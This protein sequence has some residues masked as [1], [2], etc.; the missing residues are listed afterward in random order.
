MALRIGIVDTGV[1]PWHSHVRGAVG[2]CRIFVDA[3]GFIAEDDDFRDP[4]GHGTAIAG[5]VREAFADAEIFAVRVFD[6]EDRT[7]PS[8]VARGLLRAAAEG[9]SH[10][11]LSLAV[12]AGAGTRV[13]AEA[14]AAALDAGCVLVA[15]QHPH[16]PDALPAALLGV[17]V[18]RADD[19]L[20]AGRVRREGPLRLAAP[21][22]PRE[23]AAA[24]QRNNLRGPSF[25]CARVL[26]HLAREGVGAEG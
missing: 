8:L 13:L 19:S 9:C 23:L 12:P 14:C 26:L 10:I 2:G 24:L 3:Q 11:N 25:A 7:Y 17:H 22:R 5:L 20:P 21:D 15:P 6:D 18:A 4:V 16:W 1:N